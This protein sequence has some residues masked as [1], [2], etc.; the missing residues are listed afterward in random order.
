M[1]HRARPLDAEHP[2]PARVSQ[3]APRD[4]VLDGET[5]TRF[6]RRSPAAALS[7]A[8]RMPQGRARNRAYAKLD[9][10]LARDVAPARRAE[11]IQRGDARL[12]PRRLHRAAAGSR[13]RGRLPQGVRRPRPAPRPRRDRP[14]DRRSRP[15]HCRLDRLHDL[16]RLGIDA[17]DRSGCAFATQTAPAPNATA[18]GPSPT[19]IG[20]E[21]AEAPIG[22]SIL[23]TK[24]SSGLATQIAPA[25]AAIPLGARPTVR[26]RRPG[27]PSN[28]VGAEALD[29]RVSGSRPRRSRTQPRAPGGPTAVEPRP[30]RRRAS[31]DRRA[32]VS[33][34]RTRPTPRPS[35]T[36]TAGRRTL[37]A[38]SRDSIART[39]C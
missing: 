36:S 28:V 20:I 22:R 16:V 30:R 38:R 25:P 12:E 13:S 18:V 24:S 35:P 29:A 1:G 21:R 32:R 7:R 34:P 17:R 27:P 10:L 2:G 5:L 6:R 19:G 15:G 26:D 14:T 37:I 31:P 3:P 11:R 8:A 9:A 23:V 39:R 4:A 33:S